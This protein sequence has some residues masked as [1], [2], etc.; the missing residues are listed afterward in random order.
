M[1]QD[2]TG[3][4]YV[5]DDEAAISAT[6]TAILNNA[7]FRAVGFTDPLKA[8][9]AAQFEAPGFLISDIMMPEM[10]GIELAIRFKSDCPKCKILLFSGHVDTASL[11]AS[12]TQQGHDFEVLPKPFHPTQMLEAIRNSVTGEG[13][14]AVA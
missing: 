3:I 5:V 2:S 14:G 11:L 4:V 8:L 9:E 12:A 7:G 10:N 6:L 1:Q 13:G